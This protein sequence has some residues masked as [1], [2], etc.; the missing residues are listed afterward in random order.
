MGPTE[1]DCAR[2]KPTAL[3]PSARNDHVAVR[4]FRIAYDGRPYAGFQ[5]QPN[6]HTVEDAILDGLDWLGLVPDDADLPPGYAA[7]GRTDAGVSALRQTVAF[8]CPDWCSA[9]A[10]TGSF[11]PGVKAWAAADVDDD[12]HATHDATRRTYTYHLYAP[13][14]RSRSD[15]P[16]EDGRPGVGFGASAP[17]DADPSGDVRYA[18]PAVDDAAVREAAELLSGE[19][20]FHNFTPD[21]RNT[22]RDLTLDVERDGPVLVFTVSAGGFVREQVRRL[23]S[24]VQDV[25]AGERSLGDAERLLGPD[26]V[27]G[28]D[29]VGPAPPE[30]LVLT[31]VAYPGV[32]FEVDT[33]AVASARAVFAERRIESELA[34]RVATQIER[35][36]GAASANGSDR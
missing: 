7:A 10:L 34:T 29:G 6:A 25:G 11:P 9:S 17:L 12:F 23:V 27:D 5:R 4:A 24:C 36:V 20:D 2:L 35:A 30:P 1:A 32:T 21:D 18:Y 28:G 3:S 8:D 22:V 19:H 16:D 13:K 15:D 26:P 33:D 31:D 14:A